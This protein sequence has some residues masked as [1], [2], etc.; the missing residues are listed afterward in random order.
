MGWVDESGM[1][2]CIEPLISVLAS[3][4]S[5]AV[6]SDASEIERGF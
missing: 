5:I 3:D 1:L 2:L 6:P 4:G